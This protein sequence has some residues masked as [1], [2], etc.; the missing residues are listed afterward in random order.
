MMKL[1][2]LKIT[3]K[4]RAALLV[5]AEG[6]ENGTLKEDAFDMT[7][8][9]NCDDGLSSCGTAGCIAGWAGVVLAGEALM[10][11]PSGTAV[12]A[13]LYWYDSTLSDPINALFYPRDVRWEDIKPRVA[14]AAIRQ[15]LDTGTVDWPTLISRHRGG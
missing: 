5:V 3:G 6:L 1:S 14:A 12:D 11:R 9:M 8:V 15:F 13:A 10:Q 2:E 4:E 7:N